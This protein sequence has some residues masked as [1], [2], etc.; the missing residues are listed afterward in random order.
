MSKLDN[1]RVWALVHSERAALV[2][3]LTLLDDELWATP[4]LCPGWTVHDVAAHLV[5]NARAS[6]WRLGW[7]MARAGFNFD[8]QNQNGV[9]R[10]RGATPRETLE[11]LRA[12]AH[13]TDTP[14]VD[15]ASRL[16]EEI[17]HGEDIRRPL[18]ITRD[19]PATAVEAALDYQC[20]T[21]VNVGGA[22]QH[23]ESLRLVASDCEFE[24]GDGPTVSGP[25]AAIL[26][27]ISG[28]TEALA[29]V[30]G[31]GVAVLEASLR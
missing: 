4:S 9:D 23:V 19:Y 10:E 5:D 8:R 30:S 2:D 29:D 26:I 24:R 6:L 7:S 21:S 11:R 20:A 15:R 1:D 27:A 14:P 31:D 28:R 16:V 22:R 18:G 13:R 3:D 25:G 17:V 12:V